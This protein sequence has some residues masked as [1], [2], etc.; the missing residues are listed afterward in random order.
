MR[1]WLALLAVAVTAA[2]LFALGCGTD[3]VGVAA[4]KQIEEARCHRAVSASCQSLQVTPPDY[5]GSWEDGCVRFYDVACQHGLEIGKDPG[6]AV[7]NACVKA[8]QA[9]NV[10][11]DIANPQNL[12]DCSWLEPPTSTDAGGDGAE[13]GD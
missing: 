3:A 7:V 13:G 12:P 4:C 9:T 1:R 11:D 5:V 6:A 10:C 2:L 8:I